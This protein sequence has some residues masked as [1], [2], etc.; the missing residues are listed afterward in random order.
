MEKSVRNL[1]W[2]NVFGLSLAREQVLAN[3]HGYQVA[4]RSITA[5]QSLRITSQVQ[6]CNLN[7]GM[8]LSERVTLELI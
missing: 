5:K 1:L 2:S 8:F 7:S 6:Y 3:L 4:M